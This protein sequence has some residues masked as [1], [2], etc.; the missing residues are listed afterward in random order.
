MDG[1]WGG[2]SCGR[3]T[4]SWTRALLY[5]SG[6]LAGPESAGWTPSLC[7]C[8]VLSCGGWLN[9]VQSSWGKKCEN[10]ALAAWTLAEE[11]LGGWWSGWSLQRGCLW[12]KGRAAPVR[13]LTLS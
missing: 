12:N 11:H 8:G 6:S 7:L 4:W 2:R 3:R 1:Y 13:A 5:S 9:D 10:P